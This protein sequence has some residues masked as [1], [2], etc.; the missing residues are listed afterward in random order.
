VVAVSALIVAA[1]WPAISVSFGFSGQAMVPA[2]AAPDGASPTVSAAV[3][4]TA[5]PAPSLAPGPATP[6]GTSGSPEPVALNAP[7]VIHATGAALSWP[8]Y[9]NITGDP[10]NDLAAYEVHRGTSSDFTPSAAT[11]VATVNAHDTSF[12]DTTA[13][14]SSG[15]HAGDYFYMVAVRTRSGQLIG[16]AT[17]FVQLPGPG[18]TE[19]VLPVDA[20]AT[21]GAG[22]PDT[23]V[24]PSDFSG[25]SV[26]PDIAGQG[27]E[28]AIFEFGPLK[29]I[30]S[31]A[32]VADARLSVWC[33]GSDASHIAVYALTRTFDGS[34]ATWN[35]AANGI[36][37]SRPG[38]DYT[39]PSGAALPMDTADPDVCE[40]DATAI[41]RSWTSSGGAEHG[42]L[43]KAGDETSSAGYGS[44]SAGDTYF[45]EH[46]PQ[47]VV[48]YVSGASLD[49][50]SAVSMSTAR[51]ARADGRRAAREV[52]RR[53][54]DD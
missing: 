34:Q 39:T 21:L 14:A 52:T 24:D 22:A 13:S 10:A 8:P 53:V 7:T 50:S 1:C 5:P 44:F 30:P 15:P 29:A 25:L 28:R 32:A 51:L 41:V 4:M 27:A 2:E 33:N 48:T 3:S 26:S 20:A 6:G 40:F 17:R 9:V 43:L 23:V 31:G 19:V 36:A 37:W 46:R 47:L 42:L 35:S 11:L 54:S 12:I 16:G 18:Q 45:P 38:G 49:R